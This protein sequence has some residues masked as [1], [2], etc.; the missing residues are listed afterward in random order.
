MV[1]ATSRSKPLINLIFI[2]S[3]LIAGCGSD[4]A[5]SESPTGISTSSDESAIPSNTVTSIQTEDVPITEDNAEASPEISQSPSGEPS[6]SAPIPTD[7]PTDSTP[8]PLDSWMEMP[9]IPIVS[10]TA[11][12][13]YQ[14][15]LQMGRNPSAF[16]KVGD[17]QNVA[18]LFLSIFDQ[19]GYYSLGDYAYLQEAIDWFSGSFSRVSLAVQGGFNVASV[20]SPLRADPTQCESGESPL[21]CE[22]RIHNPSFVIISME[23]WWSQ[24]P[25]EV[26][27][28]YMRQILEYTMAQ[29]VVP[30][31]ATKADN[32]EGNHGINA[33]IGKLAREYDVPLWNFWLAVQPLPNH[34]LQADNFHLT[35]AGN[36][37]DDPQRMLSAWPNRNLT[38]LQALDT[39]WRSVS[40]TTSP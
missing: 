32:L 17:C 34:G 5:I 9:V 30:I 27:E 7:L 12:E 14:L 11:L 33:T 4:P 1:N 29:G 24:S 38:A 13:I 15:G 28:K 23:T 39:V 10:E 36:Y 25:E 19:P 31:L 40:G 20:L 21:A 18:S 35:F 22:L 26:Y 3:V 37:F 6:E 8:L 2:V 16:S